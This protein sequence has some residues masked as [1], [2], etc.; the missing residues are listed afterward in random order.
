MEERQDKVS[1][2]H[3]ESTGDQS[4]LSTPAAGG[5]SKKMSALAR[6]IGVFL[7]PSRVMDNLSAKP[8]WLLPLIIMLVCSFIFVLFAG[9]VIRDFA[10]EKT[11]ERMQVQVDR[12][13]MSQEQVDQ[14][15]EQQEKF[16]GVGL[17]IQILVSVPI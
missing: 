1:N 11:S 8:D 2:E 6:V 5:E 7:E 4:G 13:N 3:P 14:I 9:D 17:Y 15:M 12:G 10:L 16:M